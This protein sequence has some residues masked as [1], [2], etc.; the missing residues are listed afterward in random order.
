[1]N[2]L[3]TILI[4]TTVLSACGGGSSSSG[5]DDQANKNLT[6]CVTETV[7][8]QN[9]FTLTNNCGLAINLSTSIITG[10]FETILLAI[11][12]THSGSVDFRGLAY[13]AC[14]PPSTGIDSNPDLPLIQIGCS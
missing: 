9:N 3:F 4:L 5:G 11:N 2:K 8:E 13:I 10:P 14:R 12:G 7:T 6:H 1:M